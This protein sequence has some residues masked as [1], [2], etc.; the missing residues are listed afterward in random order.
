MINKLNINKLPLKKSITRVSLMLI[1]AIAILLVS[2]QYSIR[3]AKE[4]MENLADAES[5]QKSTYIN[6]V[7]NMIFMSDEWVSNSFLA[8]MTSVDCYF[9][10]ITNEYKCTHVVKNDILNKLT[11]NEIYQRLES[12]TEFNDDFSSTVLVFE[13]NVLKNAPD[14]IAAAVCPN[15]SVRYN[16]CLDYQLFNGG[17][18]EL[19]KK[20][21]RQMIKTGNTREDSLL[22]LTSAVPLYNE[23]GVIIGEFW[24]DTKVD[25]FSNLLNIYNEKFAVFSLIVDDNCKVVASAYSENNGQKLKD[26]MLEPF[27]GRYSQEWYSELKE[28]LTLEKYSY[29]RNELMEES[30]VTYVFPIKG[31]SNKL[32]IIKPERKLYGDISRFVLISIALMIASVLITSI[33]LFYIYYLF[34]KKND[35]NKRMENELGLAAEI[36]RGILP[37]NTQNT[38]NLPF[39][40]YGFQRSAKT[41]GGDLYDFV[42]KGDFLHFCIG[43]VS[44][45]GMPAALVMTELCSLYRYIICYHSDP[46]EIVTLINK[47][48]M[49]RSDDS[50]FCTLFVGVLNLKTGMLEFCNAGHNPPVFICKENSEVNFLKIKPNMPIYAFE[51]F[52]YQKESLQL[53][54]GDRLFVY[55]DGVTEAKNEINEFMGNEF[56]LKLIQKFK[57]QPFNLL[58]DDFIKDLRAFTG[59]AEQNDD[60]TILCVEY[61]GAINCVSLHYDKVKDNVTKIVDDVVDNCGLDD[62]MR[63][64]LAIEEPIQNIADYAYETDGN[65]DIEISKSIDNKIIEVTLIDDGKPF[66][67]LESKLPDLSVP[68]EEREIGGLGIFLTR[69]IMDSVSYEFVN[70]Q[71]RLKLK[72]KIK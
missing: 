5:E 61:K 24:V 48:V 42:Q 36:Q 67:P 59:K 12:F 56:T 30:V 50:M 15:D 66:N 70:Q 21:G 34:K 20:T 27:D 31:S 3:M 39:D 45:K 37:I 54:K 1:F 72:Y 19:V 23:S 55:T 11:V 10:S 51:N 53:K 71:N 44:G 58:I 68:I 26:S 18:Y 22:V 62:D 28:H 43:D 57:N 29:F 8:G 35:E 16:L 52:K 65:V 32:L 49:E 25:F 4:K 9:D 60:I 38:D 64:R 6:A 69:K 41:V 2:M 33:C 17:F 7:M 63:F 13:P 47:A 46:Q 40:I 14:G